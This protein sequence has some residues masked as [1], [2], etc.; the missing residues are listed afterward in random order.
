MHGG[1]D[2]F[3]RLA[4]HQR[5]RGR[6]APADHAVVGLDAHQHIVG[7]ADFLAGHDHRLAHRQ[8]DRD[9]LDRLDVHDAYIFLMWALSMM[10]LNMPIS[11]VTRAHAASAPFGRTWKPA[12]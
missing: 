10:S 6:F 9:R 5:R 12:L 11:L 3:E 8:A 1:D 2:A 4:G 7:A